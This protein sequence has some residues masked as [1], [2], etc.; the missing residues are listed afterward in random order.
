VFDLR[1]GRKY[2]TKAERSAFFTIAR[3]LR[4]KSERAFCLFLYYTGCRISEALSICPASIDVS[5][6]N[7]VIETLKRRKNGVF[8]SIPIPDKF[9]RLLQEVYEDSETAERIWRFSRTTGYRFIKSCMKAARINGAMAS[10]KGL[11]HGFAVAC[12]QE[13]IALTVVKNWMGHARLETTAIYLNV[14]GQEE[15]AMAKRLWKRD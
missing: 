7:A 3:K 8:R 11:R 1:G 14:M 2:L 9:V 10:P 5:E 15:R 6:R 12:I 4:N 13:N